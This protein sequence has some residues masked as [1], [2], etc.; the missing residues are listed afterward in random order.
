MDFK[1]KAL[2]LV[3]KH[4]NVGISSESRFFTSITGGLSFVGVFKN[5][6]E[7]YGSKLYPWLRS[8]QEMYPIKPDTKR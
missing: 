6:A 7:T 8:K 3:L 4:V 1:A 2:S 5:H